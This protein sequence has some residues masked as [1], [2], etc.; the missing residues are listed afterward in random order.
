MGRVTA[1]AGSPSARTTDLL[2]VGQLTPLHGRRYIIDIVMKGDFLTWG[3]DLP[4]I[5][6]VISTRNRGE[7]IAETIETILLNDYPDFEVR[8]IDQSDGDA[9]A[10]ALRRFLNDPRLL[11]LR[12]TSRGLSA[13]RNLG[14]QGARNELVAI[15]DDDCRIPADWLRELASSFGVDRRIGVVFGSVHPGPHD[16]GRGF[17]MSYSRKGSYLARSVL[18]QYRLECLAA[19]MGVRK[20][21]WRAL[22]GFDELLGAGAPFPSAEE[23]DFA[24][25]T[26]S[27]GS[28]VYESP[29]FSVLHLG[30][31]TWEQ[32]LALIRRLPLRYRS[33][34]RKTSEASTLA[35]SS[36]SLSPGG[37]VGLSSAGSRFRASSAAMAQASGVCAGTY[38]RRSPSR[39]PGYRTFCASRR[40]SGGF[41][42]QE[43]GS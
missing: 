30:F 11:Y 27:A 43:R 41:P 10:A 23:M 24:I 37:A 22:G 32:G 4:P 31:R 17:I 15:T 9:T 6:V 42:F 36:P 40:L 29:A 39:G 5:T 14:I 3:S 34:P 26:L 7:R 18:D 20:S 25:R 2:A 8:V 19:C 12:T 28:Y 38:S 16:S 33:G 21:V 13:G 1:S 35:Y